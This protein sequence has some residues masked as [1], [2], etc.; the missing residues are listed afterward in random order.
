MMICSKE[1]NNFEK[2]FFGKRENISKQNLNAKSLL[3]K[4][5]I[6]PNFMFIN[7]LQSLIR[8]DRPQSLFYFVSHSQA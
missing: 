1:K 7:I 2:F 4:K 6:I 3:N 5:A 8:A